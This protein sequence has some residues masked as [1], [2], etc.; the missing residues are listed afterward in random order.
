MGD[1]IMIS[2]VEVLG[3]EGMNYA[4]NEQ[5]C[6]VVGT[7][8]SKTSGMGIYTLYPKDGLTILAENPYD[9][10]RL[11]E[12]HLGDSYINYRLDNVKDFTKL[13]D[14][15]EEN[16]VSPIGVLGVSRTCF[17]IDDKEMVQTVDNI[18]NNISFMRMLRYALFLLVFFIGFISAF[19][20]MR[21]RK[22]EIAIIRSLGTG[23]VRTFFMF[24]LEYAAIGL[25]GVLLA[26]V[27]LYANMGSRINGQY[28]Y[29][30]IFYAQIQQ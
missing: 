24:F 30:L 7:Y 28:T 5:L 2:K 11:Q 3:E 16:G 4:S 13:R 9:L 14:K 12:Y 27:I 6:H 29:V 17:V 8:Q 23:K 22:T 1:V 20:T 15:L 19:M 21:T 18:Q 25:A 10:N 26:M